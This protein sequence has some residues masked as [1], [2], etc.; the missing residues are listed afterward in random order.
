[1]NH[2][3]NPLTLFCTS[4]LHCGVWQRYDLNLLNCNNPV[5]LYDTH[6]RI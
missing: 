2:T 3:V 4:E 6:G 5:H 1:M